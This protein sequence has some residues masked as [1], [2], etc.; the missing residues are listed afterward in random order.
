M[1]ALRVDELTEAEFERHAAG[2]SLA[3]IAAARASG[4]RQ[5]ESASG[6][7]SLRRLMVPGG[8]FV[9]DAPAGVPTVWGRDGEVLWARGE[10]LMLTGGSGVGKTTLSVQLVRARLGM[11]AEVLGLP[12]EPGAARVLYLAMDRPAQVQRAMRR[13]FDSADRD[14]LERRLIVW[15]GPPPV[16]LAKAPGVLAEMCEAA[17]AD[18]VFVDSLKDAALGLSDDVVGAGYNR[19]RQACLTAGIEVVEDHHNVKRGPAGGPPT[20]LAD[21]YG[22]TWLTGG[23]GSVIGL[24]GDPGDPV[25]MFRHLK[26][27]AEEVGPWT[28]RH[29]HDTGVTTVMQGADLLEL[30]RAVGSLTVG[31]AAAAMFGLDKPASRAQQEKARRKLARLVEAG[32]LLPPTVEPGGAALYRPAARSGAA[33]PGSDLFGEGA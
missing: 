11:Q 32:L 26:Q 20:S 29:D 2:E 23:C 28:L 30:A 14:I 22:S 12:V 1:T 5:E 13:R 10:A 31:A 19:A 24:H 9:L 6:T 15:K 7:E 4:L 16:D 25:V 18:T 8:R 27:P 17:G 3:A 33:E 21:V